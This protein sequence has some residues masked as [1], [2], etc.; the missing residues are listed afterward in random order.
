MAK[1]LS[2]PDSLRTSRSIF[3]GRLTRSS[4][5]STS[6]LLGTSLTDTTSEIIYY[7]LSSRADEEFGTDR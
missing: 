4:P 5:L 7:S 3:Q 1:E 2:S 6:L